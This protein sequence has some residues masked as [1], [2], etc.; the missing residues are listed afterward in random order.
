MEGF[1]PDPPDE[2]LVADLNYLEMNRTITRAAGGR[3]LEVNGLVLWAGTHPSAAIVNGI[4]RMRAGEPS[5]ARVLGFAA[6]WFGEIGHGYA[7][8]VRVGG[9]A[10]LEAAALAQGFATIIE[11]P[12]MVHDGPPPE[13]SVPDGYQ[14]ARVDDEQGLR[15]LVEAVGEPF[16]LPQEVASVFARPAY[17]LPPL[18]GAVV[19]R[20]AGGRPVAGAWTGLSHSVA[21]I[22]FVGTAEEARG[23][24]LGTAVTAAAM[25]LG[26]SMGASS[27]VLQA[28]PMGK[29]VY[30]R[31]G[32]REIGTTYRI[33]VDPAS[34]AAMHGTH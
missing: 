12:V 20:D 19:A 1:D 3:L 21:V 34:A 10:D 14:I 26:F 16:E 25:G 4:M 30:A 31:M 5:P 8:S 7:V 11:L 9:D 17:A 29:P 15:D 13:V 24:G 23:R 2:L 28:S 33:L 22:G 18:T 27:A 32:F 6:E